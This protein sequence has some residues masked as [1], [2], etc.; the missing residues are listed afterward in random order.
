MWSTQHS[1]RSIMGHIINVSF[2]FPV[3]PHLSSCPLSLWFLPCLTNRPLWEPNENKQDGLGTAVVTGP[4]S[5]RLNTTK[6]YSLPQLHR[7]HGQW[8]LLVIVMQTPRLMGLPSQHAGPWSYWWRVGTWW[9]THWFSQ[10]LPGNSI[11]HFH[12]HFRSQN[13]SQGNASFQGGQTEKYN[14]TLCPEDGEPEVCGEEHHDYHQP[15]AQGK[16]KNAS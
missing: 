3:L 15:T 8:A 12:S 2:A 14:P 6:V 1:V 4:R 16:E 11:R 13:K 5:S 9:I 10:C 7:Q